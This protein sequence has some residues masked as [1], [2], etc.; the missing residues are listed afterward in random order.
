MIKII[1]LSVILLLISACSFKSPP[2]QWQYKSTTA[3]NSYVK[4]FLSSNVA[5][6]RND[7]SRATKY[8]KQSADLTMLARIYLGVCALNIS[9]GV[10]DDC[11]N[12]VDISTLLNDKSLDAYYNFITIKSNN[13]IENLNDQYKSFAQY[14]NKKEFN[15]AN[16]EILKI[17]KPTSKLLA[18][19]LMKENLTINTINEMIETAS[20]HGYKKSVIFWLNEKKIKTTDTDERKI[21]SKKISVIKSKD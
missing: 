18:S 17:S 15:N 10:D 12:Y 11:K 3:Y 21:I 8:A 1:I 2:N 6:A 7:L 5:L 16:K 9:V 4:N 13:S 14:L 20:F 19:S